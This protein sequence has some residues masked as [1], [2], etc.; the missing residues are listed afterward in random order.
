[1]TQFPPGFDKDRPGRVKL[2]GAVLAL[3][4]LENGRQVR[5]RMHQLSR[6]GGILQLSDPLD[7]AVNVKLLFHV[8]STTV[9]GKAEM[10]F[11]MWAT[12]GCLQPFRFTEL[13]DEE[14]SRLDSD[15]KFFLQGFVEEQPTN[16]PGEPPVTVDFDS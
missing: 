15:L 14:R 11:P 3:V 1:M 4:Q 2:A 12:S 13:S 9:H 8:G 6:N 16:K 5:A 10:M 7:E